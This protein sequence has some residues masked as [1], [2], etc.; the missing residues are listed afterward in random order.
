M[1]AVG[2]AVRLG[3]PCVDVPGVPGRD[4]GARGESQR[5][6]LS[7][8]GTEFVLEWEWLPSWRPQDITEDGREQLRAIGFTAF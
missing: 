5:A 3:R 4:L 2:F 8:R 7:E 1:R 6:V